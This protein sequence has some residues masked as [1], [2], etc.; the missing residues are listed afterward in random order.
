MRQAF[1]LFFYTFFT[2]SMGANYAVPTGKQAHDYCCTADAGCCT[3]DAP[4]DCCLDDREDE[5]PFVQIVVPTTTISI[6][7]SMLP[8]AMQWLPF[9]AAQEGFSLGVYAGLVH[10]VSS[11]IRFHQLIFYA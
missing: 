4:M 9:V 3:T 11:Y 2:F 1:V 8:K 5:P 7:P 6:L 10:R